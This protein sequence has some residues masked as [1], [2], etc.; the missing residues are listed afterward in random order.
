MERRLV[1]VSCDSLVILRQGTQHPTDD[2]WD[3]CMRILQSK[4]LDT[5]KV[6]VITEGGSP[7]PRQQNRLGEV[8]AGKAI[9]A[10]VVSESA[11]VRFVVSSV[12]LITRR[13]RIRSFYMNDLES[14]YT[15]LRLTREERQ[16]AIVAIDETKRLLTRNPYGSPPY[17]GS[18]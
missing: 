2:E 9:P 17:E 6:L 14:A 11:L 15:H 16:F 13:I 5:V 3:E 7:S 1:T 18:R 4:D 10:A 12:A 8:L